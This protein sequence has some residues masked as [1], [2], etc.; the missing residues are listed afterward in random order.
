MSAP[1]DFSVHNS[2]G[3]FRRQT[4]SHSS[5]H[6]AG[7]ASQS[8]SPNR[9]SNLQR[10]DTAEDTKGGNTTGAYRA[11][12]SGRT[13]RIQSWTQKPAVFDHPL[14]HV[15]TTDVLVDFDGPDGPYRPIIWPLRKKVITTVLYD[16]TTASIR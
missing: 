7:K 11:T 9:P 12:S 4:T 1:L 10:A 15:K 8:S 6:D 5:L 3:L 16:F 2:S 14:S 13:S